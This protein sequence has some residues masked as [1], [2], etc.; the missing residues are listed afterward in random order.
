MA[1]HKKEGTTLH[2][3]QLKTTVLHCIVSVIHL[4]LYVCD[5]IHTKS[6]AVL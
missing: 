2:D 5:I 3:V 4:Y 6:S 1:R